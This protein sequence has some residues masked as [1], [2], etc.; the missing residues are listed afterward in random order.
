MSLTS[1]TL[2][3]EELRRL[4]AQ[5]YREAMAAKAP[6]PSSA[7]ARITA[8][9]PSRVTKPRS[10]YG[11]RAVRASGAVKSAHK[12]ASGVLVALVRALPPQCVPLRVSP[13][14]ASPQSTSPPLGARAVPKTT[15]KCAGSKPESSGGADFS[16]LVRKR[17]G[18]HGDPRRIPLLTARSCP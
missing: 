7:F 15:R 1:I 3:M 9:K 4:N 10:R 2:T 13:K 18:T 16:Q 14:P 6:A 5:H 17:K 12:I 11:A 8:P